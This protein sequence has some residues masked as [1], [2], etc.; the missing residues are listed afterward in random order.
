MLELLAA[1]LV[2]TALCKLLT[3]CHIQLMVDNMTA[4]S[5]I[6]KMGGTHS[7]SCNELAR[8]IWLWAKD[9]NIWLSAEHIAG[10]ENKISDLSLEILKLPLNGC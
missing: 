10:K 9:K 4:V 3:N 7:K 5:Y 1:K 6:N 2:L 8:E